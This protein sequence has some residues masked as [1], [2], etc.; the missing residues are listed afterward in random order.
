MS[1]IQLFSSVAGTVPCEV[2][3]CFARH[4]RVVCA[5]SVR[6][7]FIVACW[8]RVIRARRALCFVCRQRA[9]SRVSA[10][11]FHAVVLFRVL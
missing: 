2:A 9:V 1:P 10:R 7:V 4:S 6:D 5:L 3:C 11:R 8:L